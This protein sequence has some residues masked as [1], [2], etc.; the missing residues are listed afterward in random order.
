MTM[1]PE[2]TR[3]SSGSTVH[4]ILWWARSHQSFVFGP[5][6]LFSLHEATTYMSWNSNPSTVHWANCKINFPRLS[7]I[8]SQNCAL[9]P[10]LSYLASV[11]LNSFHWYLFWWRKDTTRDFLVRIKLHFNHLYDL[12]SLSSTIHFGP[13]IRV[14]MKRQVTGSSN[15]SKSLDLSSKSSIFFKICDLD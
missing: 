9:L 8:G 11:I 4:M 15:L 14:R 10:W 1:I 13:R 6:S 3:Y 2:N 7:S 5:A 12:C